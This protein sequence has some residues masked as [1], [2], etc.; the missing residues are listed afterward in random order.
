M[1][2]S[3]LFTGASRGESRVGEMTG[4]ATVAQN[5]HTADVNRQIRS[6]VP[7]QTLR[8][9]IV[10]RNG[11]E[12]QIRISEDMVLNAKVDQSIHL[13]IGQNVTFEVKS[14]GAALSLS[15]LFTN[16]SADVNVLKAPNHPECI[17]CGVCMKACPKD[18][19]H[20]RFMGK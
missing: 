20:Y 7:G 8:G 19:I 18:A 12:I 11:G 16:I 10:S 17:R 9:E 4:R 2:L 6:L 1:N 5:L 15:P 3:Q 13:D 14:N